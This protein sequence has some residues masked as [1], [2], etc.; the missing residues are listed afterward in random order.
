MLAAKSDLRHGAFLG[1]T[2]EAQAGVF[3]RAGH[4]EDRTVLM[5]QAA[6]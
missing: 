2:G 1:M 6:V 4:P 5:A 3:E